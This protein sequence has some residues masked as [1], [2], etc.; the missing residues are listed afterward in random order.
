MKTNE[1]TFYSCTIMA[2]I[3]NIKKATENKNERHVKIN[4]KTRHQKIYSPREESIT[5]L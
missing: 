1:Q 2:N 4:L 3:N 5:A